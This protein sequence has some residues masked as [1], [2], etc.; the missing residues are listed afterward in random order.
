MWPNGLDELGNRSE[1]RLPREG[2][3]VFDVD[4]ETTHGA[5][6]LCV[7]QQNLDGAKVARLPMDDGSLSSPERMRAVVLSPQ[8]DPC[9]SR[10]REPGADVTGMVDL[11]W[12]DEVVDQARVSVAKSR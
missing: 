3:G 7:T 2:Q 5:P 1:F 4:A 10:A 6:D 9:D 11:P 8:A 12:K